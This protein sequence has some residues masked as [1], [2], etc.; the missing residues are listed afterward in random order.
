[1]KNIS[2]ILFIFTC[3]VSAQGQSPL[4][5]YDYLNQPCIVNPAACGS[6]PQPAL[7]L[8]Y[9][10][11]WLNIS[12]SPS[13]YFLNGEM[14]IGN[15]DLYT[16][17][18]FINET[19]FRSLE[20]VGLG[21]G[22]YADNNGPFHE[23]N[24]VLTYSYHLP[25]NT[26][27]NLS[28]GISGKLNYFGVN[29]RELDPVSPGDPLI[30]FD[31]YVNLNSNIGTYLYHEEYFA[32][33]SAVN[34]FN[35]GDDP[36]YFTSTN[37]IIYCFAGYRFRNKNGSILLEPSLAMKYVLESN[38]FVPDYHVKIYAS[39]YGWLNCSYM[40]NN[41]LKLILAIR[42]HDDWYVGY[43]MTSVQSGLRTYAKNTHGIM[44]GINLG[45]NELKNYSY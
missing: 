18:K 7:S 6:G 27:T 22:I 15:Y 41:R 34:L 11:Q 24:L 40:E 29:Q 10:R 33:V 30:E 1:M 31:R 13:S 12:Q 39:G 25:L 17:R 8:S 37:Q 32:G 44:I 5:S 28:F 38:S 19:N 36:F 2:T 14:R 35:P 26:R 3:L 43:K 20:R 45:V 21:A 4:N 42:V 16:P 23:T 9:D